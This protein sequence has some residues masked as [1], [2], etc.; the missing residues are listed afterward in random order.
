MAYNRKPN[1]PFK[2]WAIVNN[3]ALFSVYA[4]KKEAK[5]AFKLSHCLKHFKIIKLVQDI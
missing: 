5:L 3:D 2:A 4:T 1:T